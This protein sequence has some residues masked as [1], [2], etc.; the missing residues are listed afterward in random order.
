[1]E[2]LAFAA[3]AGA[4]QMVAP[5]RWMPASV[6]AWQKGWRSSRVASF[7]LLALIV[8]LSLGFLIY[9]LIALLPI[10][11]PS[12]SLGVF[13]LIF[14]GAVG[15]IRAL[16]FS[17][18]REVLFRSPDS[19]RAIYSILSLLGP[20]EMVVPVLMKA[21][22]EGMPLFPMWVALLLGSWITG[23]VILGFTRVSW[24]RPMAL[25]SAVQWCRSRTAALPMMAGALIGI[26]LI[27]M[28]A[29]V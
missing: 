28:H 17:R 22:L 6:L 18:F 11:I 27:V 2:L 26:A 7:S 24:N 19:R 8:H 10:A 15:T 25:P 13:T 12:D 4:I 20:S 14:L 1:M 23:L 5:D 9:G 3:I 21:K 29:P 16:R